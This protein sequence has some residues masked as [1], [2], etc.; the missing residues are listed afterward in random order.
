MAN[1][2]TKELG[3]YEQMAKD[4]G[5]KTGKNKQPLIASG[6]GYEVTVNPKR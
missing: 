3:K 4:K 5:G 1:E 6:K 2:E